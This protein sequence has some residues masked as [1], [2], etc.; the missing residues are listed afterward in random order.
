MS[1]RER[2]VGGLSMED[3]WERESGCLHHSAILL[4]DLSSAVYGVGEHW[5]YDDSPEA[6]ELVRRCKELER[7]LNGLFLR[8]DNSLT[9]WQECRRCG[10][11]GS[12]RDEDP[13]I[14][15]E[16]RGAVRP[17]EEVS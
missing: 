12:F 5:G 14:E 13:C 6:V 17:S 3:F 9:H 8:A 10:G 7:Y 2:V 1:T 11:A 16:G 15:C 4:Q